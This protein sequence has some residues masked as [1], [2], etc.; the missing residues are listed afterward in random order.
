MKKQ[1]ILIAT[2]LFGSLLLGACNQMDVL[3]RFADGT[4]RREVEYDDTHA[5]TEHITDWDK[6]CAL[7]GTGGCPP[8]WRS[9]KVYWWH[10][11]IYHEFVGFTWGPFVHGYRTRIGGYWN[12]TEGEWHQFL[13]CEAL[14]IFETNRDCTPV[15]I[16]GSRG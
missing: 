15:G 5:D 12:R 7:L 4:P 2:V 10:R 14:P 1:I 11:H 3:E 9:P 6:V 13:T 8:P 16:A